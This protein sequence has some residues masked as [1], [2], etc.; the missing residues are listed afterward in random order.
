ME[1]LNFEDEGPRARKALPEQVFTK[2]PEEVKLVAPFVP[3]VVMQVAT[4]LLMI[5][6]V[7][8]YAVHV[9]ACSS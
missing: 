3:G 5:V 4:L 2:D 8:L 9:N 6:M 7:C 1:A